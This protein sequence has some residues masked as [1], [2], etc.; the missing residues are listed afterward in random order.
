M[1]IL[2]DSVD[3]DAT[4]FANLWSSQEAGTAMCIRDRDSARVGVSGFGRSDAARA[5]ALAINLEKAYNQKKEVVRAAIRAESTPKA[6]NRGNQLKH[7]REDGRD[8]GNRSYLYGT[9]E[10]AQKLVDQYSGTGEPKL[11]RKGNWTHKEFVMADYIIGVAVNPETGTSAPTRR[12]AIHY[13]KRGTH[14]VPMEEKK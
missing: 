6:L 10:D 2:G 8:I 13:G 11:D 1:Q 12:F 7:S 14:I 4:A 9:L 3:G 5:G